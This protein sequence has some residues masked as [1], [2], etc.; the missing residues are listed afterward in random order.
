[1]KQFLI[2]IGLLSLTSLLGLY[3][4]FLSV[5]GYDDAY[6]LR[7]TS[8]QQS[9][10]I[11]GT[12]RAA[13]GLNPQYLNQ[14]LNRK[15]IYNYAFSV[16]DSPYGPIYLRSIQQK[17]D[18]KSRDGIF[19]ICVDAWSLSCR[20]GHPEDSSSFREVESFLDHTRW[21]NYRPN[22]HYM[23]TSYPKPYY[24]LLMESEKE[25]F[26]HDNGWLEINVPMDSALIARRT[27][28]KAADYL[29]YNL[30]VYRYSQTRWNY[31]GKTIQ[32]L[33]QHGEVFLVRLPVS[34][35]LYAIDEELFPGFS[36]SV[37]LFAQ[38]E[39][40][41]F[42]DF[43]DRRDEYVYTDGNHLSKESAITLSIGLAR[44]IRQSD[45]HVD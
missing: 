41:T 35:T 24:E 11:L 4:L 22:V 14:E 33:S 25:V 5:D 31:L 3:F 12:S 37:Q 18:P 1:M 10:L 21:V 19:I 44:L 15:D 20:N 7:F 9:S 17:V 42:I 6:Y 26:L 38:Q 8:P 40:V 13:Q 28:G 23:L 32:W 39:G 34:S 36:D 30:P 43:S 16:E 27:A 45:H 2:R 29:K